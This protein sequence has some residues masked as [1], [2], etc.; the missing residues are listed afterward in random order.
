LVEREVP[1]AAARRRHLQPRPRF[2]R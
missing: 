2:L 1:V